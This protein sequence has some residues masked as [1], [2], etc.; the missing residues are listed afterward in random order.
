[1]SGLIATAYLLAQATDVPRVA[2]SKDNQWAAFVAYDRRLSIWDLDAGDRLKTLPFRSGTSQTY[3]LA[4]S[5][6]RK[7]LIGIFN[8]QDI[9]MA[10]AF[11]TKTI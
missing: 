6:D 5:S 1:M 8:N 4:F 10:F 7:T 2:I 9:S 3:E 11:S